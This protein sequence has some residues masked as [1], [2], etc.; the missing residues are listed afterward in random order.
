MPST[1]VLLCRQWAAPL[2]LG[3]KFRPNLLKT[4][5]ELNET[6]SNGVVL[7]SRKFGQLMMIDGESV[8]LPC[9]RYFDQNFNKGARRPYW[10]FN[11]RRVYEPS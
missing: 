5:L 4:F 8:F 10:E 2:T 9:Q 11:F 7:S 6:I 1:F 3:L